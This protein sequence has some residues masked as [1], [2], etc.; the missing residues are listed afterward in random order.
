[1]ETDF[2]KIVADMLKKE[3]TARMV[4][5]GG[6]HHEMAVEIRIMWIKNTQ[7]NKTNVLDQRYVRDPAEVMH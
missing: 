6:G 1:M 7:T 4:R 3:E 2:A 5:L